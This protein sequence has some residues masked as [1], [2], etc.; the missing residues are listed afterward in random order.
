MAGCGTLWVKPHLLSPR[1]GL[2]RES[3]AIMG[4]EREMCTLTIAALGVWG[5]R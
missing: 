1:L 5:L 4:R 3:E 2:F